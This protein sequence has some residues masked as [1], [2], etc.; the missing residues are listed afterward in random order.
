[1]TVALLLV[2]A[3]IVAVALRPRGLGV[4]TIALGGALIALA[5]RLVTLHDLA[6]V[7]G[8]VWN[9]TL[10]FVGIVAISIVLDEAGVFAFLAQLAFGASRGS[11]AR[12]FVLLVVADALVAAVFA[13]DG[14][15]LILTPIVLEGV[16]AAGVSTSAAWWLVMAVGFVADAA[17]V[18]LPISNLVNLIGAEGIPHESFARYAVVMVPVD[19]LVVAVSLAVLWWWSRRHL[20]GVRLAVVTLPPGASLRDRRVALAAAV[21]MPILLVS[22]LL[23]GVLGLPISVLTALALGVLLAVAALEGWPP[24]R[25]RGGVSVVQPLRAAPWQVVVFSIGMYVVIESL[26]HTGVLASAVRAIAAV[27]RLPLGGSVVVAGL[28]SA[29]GASIV[30]NL[31]AIFLAHLGVGAAGLGARTASALTYAAIVGCDLG[32]KLTP[33]GSLATLLWLHVLEQRG[34]HVGWGRYVR[35]G[36]VLTVPVLLVVLLGLGLWLSV[37]GA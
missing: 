11:L 7:L 10:T 13:N 34:V 3:T 31:P 19:V 37:L 5:A 35:T 14:A 21:V 27:G 12:L 30:N 32:P 20:A 1:M 24:R 15:A 17:S 29:L 2:G 26:V 16:L 8:I 23:D 36:V 28:T 9:P 22:Y 25:R 6:V 4:G 18:P 33:I